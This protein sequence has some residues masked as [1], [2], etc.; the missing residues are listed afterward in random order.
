MISK[1]SLPLS[2]HGNIAFVVHRSHGAN[3]QSTYKKPN[4]WALEYVIMYVYKPVG[5]HIIMQQSEKL[6]LY[7]KLLKIHLKSN[8]ELFISIR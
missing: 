4:F 6:T 7:E 2:A 1:R 3:Q 8:M 5:F